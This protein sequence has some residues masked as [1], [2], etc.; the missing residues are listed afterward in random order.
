MS[1]ADQEAALATLFSSQSFSDDW[2]SSS[3]REQEM[4]AAVARAV[5]R[6]K[7]EYGNFKGVH[8]EPDHY[9]V[10][11]EQAE[12]PVH[13]ALDPHGRITGLLLQTATPTTGTLSSFVE[14][15]AALP[16]RTACLIATDGAVLHDHNAGLPLAVGS[17]MKL[18]ILQAV[19]VAVSERR[20]QWEQVCPLHDEDRSLPSGILQDW[21]SGARLTI[22]SLAALMISISDNTATD[23]LLRLAG[24]TAVEAIAPS[25]RPFLTTREAFILKGA[26]HAALRA[27]WLGSDAEAR[28]ALL[29]R[30]AALDVPAMPDMAPGNAPEIE[31]FL[32]A[33]ELYEHLRATRDL[34]AFRINAGP[35]DRRHWRRVAYK[36]GS[37]ANLLNMSVALGAEDGREH[38]VVATWNDLEEV[39]PERFLTPFLGIL[40]ALRKSENRST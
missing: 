2:F 4:P 31:W 29:G 16:G 9:I 35:V 30:L 32:T 27:E 37:E 34:P 22:E 19:A 18:P 28:R 10:T 23:F 6:L 15:I 21:P 12:A 3:M 14:E 36:G 25:C 39:N 26:A 1:F 17:A 24:R 40:Y 8:R 5:G 20:L 33:T 11:L 38:C 7:R 13:I